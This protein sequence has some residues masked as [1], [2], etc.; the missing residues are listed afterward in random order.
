MYFTCSNQIQNIADLRI[1]LISLF[2]GIQSFC[3]ELKILKWDTD[4]Q[5]E[6]MSDSEELPQTV[7]ALKK[8][9]NN[10][11]SPVGVPK[12]YLK[13]RLSLPIVT[14]RSTFEVDAL[15][16]PNERGVKMFLCPVQ[17]S[18]TKRVGWL[19]YPSNTID[20]D[21]WSRTVQ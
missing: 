2:Q 21:K 8:Y 11:R 6:S 10:L 15:S 16:Y 9:F 3:K 14:D 20:E 12:Q 13:L 7:T 19:A 1:Y 18:N 17:A 5:K 4:E